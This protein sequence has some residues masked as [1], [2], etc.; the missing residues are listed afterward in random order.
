LFFP[1]DD[2]ATA[3]EHMKNTQQLLSPNTELLRENPCAPH[4]CSKQQRLGDTGKVS[5]DWSV[6]R[7]L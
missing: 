7:A 3:A 6:Q 4:C 1:L 5:A 2:A